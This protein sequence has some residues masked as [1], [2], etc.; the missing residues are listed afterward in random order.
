MKEEVIKFYKDLGLMNDK[1]YNYLMNIVKFVREDDELGMSFV[2][3]YTATRLS[4]RKLEKIKVFIPYGESLKTTCIQVHEIAHFI[5]AY[6]YLEKPYEDYFGREIFPIAMER[7]F[8]EKINNPELMDWFN[9]YQK[10]L[11]DNVLTFN[12]DNYEL[13]KM[14]QEHI[15]GFLHHFDYVDF[16]NNDG[17]LPQILDF[18]VF[19]NIDIKEELDKKAKVLLK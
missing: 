7:I 18:K 12:T 2:G 16:Y 9:S 3:C 11:I 8:F 1:M 5:D 4:D 10:E 19:N 6:S 14:Q 13:K 17:T 15:L